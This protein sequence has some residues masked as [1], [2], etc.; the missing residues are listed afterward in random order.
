[1]GRGEGQNPR[2]SKRPAVE[3]PSSEEESDTE[4]EDESSTAG[5]HNKTE[6]QELPPMHSRKKMQ[7][8]DAEEAQTQWSAGLRREWLHFCCKKCGW[9][10]CLSAYLFLFYFTDSIRV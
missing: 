3:L 1:M 7:Q 4:D 6:Y 10:V 2:Y 9:Y 5:G 8:R